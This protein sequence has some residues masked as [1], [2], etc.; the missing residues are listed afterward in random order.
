MEVGRG[1]EMVVEHGVLVALALPFSLSFSMGNP[2]FELGVEHC[3][4]FDWAGSSC[5]IGSIVW[6]KA[7]W[8][9]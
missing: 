1:L 6:D 9:E 3:E 2:N 4:E 5:W 7:V 8:V